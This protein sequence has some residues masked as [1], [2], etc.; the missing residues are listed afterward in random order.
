MSP[1]LSGRF[2]G[3]DVPLRCQRAARVI[4]N[5]RNRDARVVGLI[6]SNSAAQSARFHPSDP[7]ASTVVLVTL[8][9]L[10]ATQSQPLAAELFI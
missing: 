9:W 5:A 7:Q 10:T 3:V 1:S 2:S 8:R 6:P 4:L